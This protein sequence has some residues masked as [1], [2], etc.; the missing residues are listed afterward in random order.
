MFSSWYGWLVLTGSKRRGG[1]GGGRVER[2][3]GCVL[4]QAGIPLLYTEASV[5]ADLVV[6][7]THLASQILIEKA[8]FKDTAHGVR[9]M[10]VDEDFEAVV[11]RSAGEIGAA[12][13]PE[14]EV[15][16]K[17]DE[18]DDTPGKA[19]DFMSF[20]EAEHA[21]CKRAARRPPKKMT[22]AP[23][24]SPSNVPPEQGDSEETDLVG[25]AKQ[26]LGES[27]VV[28]VLSALDMMHGEEH[29]E[30]EAAA[31][32]EQ[33]DAFEEDE[34][35]SDDDDDGQPEHNME[36]DMLPEDPLAD[37]VLEDPPLPALHQA[38]SSAGPS[39]D[40][41]RLK[42]G[43]LLFKVEETGADHGIWANL[44]ELQQGGDR[45]R[46]GFPPLVSKDQQHEDDMQVAY[47]MFAVGDHA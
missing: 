17:P 5:A 9:T 39:G 28:R 27:E 32:G 45:P 42:L 24:P 31:H 3:A 4:Q 12:V 18:E 37:T 38:A 11:I 2:P 13:V 34:K 41:D 21:E 6:S 1:V 23:Q 15:G 47:E 26:L 10:G 30:A 20:L 40:S 22:A 7:G 8:R 35:S 44:F 16:G 33:V 36:A 19:V 14:P 43:I 46:R 25:W 29:K